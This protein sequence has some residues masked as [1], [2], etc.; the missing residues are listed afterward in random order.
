M[1]DRGK[2]LKLE[3][4]VYFIMIR[5]LIKPVLPRKWKKE[6]LPEK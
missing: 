3:V 4:F 2:K 5:Y 1:R 6:K